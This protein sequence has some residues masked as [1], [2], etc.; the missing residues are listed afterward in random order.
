MQ[1]HGCCIVVSGSEEALKQL[2]RR[3]TFLVSSENGRLKFGRI[4]SPVEI[5]LRPAHYMLERCLREA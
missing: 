1:C 3:I 4:F 5:A 2:G